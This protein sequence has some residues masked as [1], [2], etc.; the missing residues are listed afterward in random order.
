MWI[1]VNIFVQKLTEVTNLTDGIRHKGPKKE[2]FRI[3]KQNENNK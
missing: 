1:R 2:I 3:M